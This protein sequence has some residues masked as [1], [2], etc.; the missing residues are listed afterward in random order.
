[1]L[2]TVT[3]REETSNFLME[4]SELVVQL[5]IFEKPKISTKYL[6]PLDAKHLLGAVLSVVFYDAFCLTFIIIKAV[7]MIMSCMKCIVHAME[8]P[9]VS[10]VAL[11][12]I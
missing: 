3:K 2:S 9:L 8:S 4:D 12:K 1:M 7:K 11:H 10:I 5:E 6:S